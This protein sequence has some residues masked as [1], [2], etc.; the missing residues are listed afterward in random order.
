MAAIIPPL[1][2]LVNMAHSK[3]NHLMKKMSSLTVR[4]RL[5]PRGAVESLTISDRS[6]G[7]SNPVKDV[8]LCFFFFL[9]FSFSFLMFVWRVLFL[10]ITFQLTTRGGEQLSSELF[11]E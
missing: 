10:L 11:V 7:G 9:F 2:R 3:K 4:S 6:V 1:L 5:I 8:F